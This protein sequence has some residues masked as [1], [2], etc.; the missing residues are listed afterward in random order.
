MN[1]TI[2]TT[3]ETNMEIDLP[4]YSKN[5]Y[6]FF[7]IVSETKAIRICTLAGCESILHTSSFDEIIKGEQTTQDEFEQAMNS[8]ITKLLSL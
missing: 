8:T 2:K 7:K 1:I 6:N 5:T 4:Y 3:T